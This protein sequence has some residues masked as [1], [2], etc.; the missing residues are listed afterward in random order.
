[1]TT[2]GR[3]VASRSLVPVLIVTATSLVI[4]L[5]LNPWLLLDSSTPSGGD[6][7]AHVYAPAYLRDVLL[8]HGRIGGWS[9]DWF[10]GFP[11]FYFYFPLPSIVIV[12][13]D[14][15][16]P[17]GVAFKLVT[18][19]GLIGMPPAVYY[20]TRSFRFN[21]SVST[22]A[23]S[24]SAVFVFMES[25]TIYGGNIASTLA[26]EF[27]YSWSFALGFV[28]LGLLARIL[29]GERDL[30]PKAVVVFAAAALSH[31]LTIIML[32]VCT[33]VFFLRKGAMGPVATVWLWA[34]L[35]TGFWSIPLLVRLPLST[36]MAWTPLSRWEEIFPIEMWLLIPFAIVGIVWAA[37]R[38][39]GVLP[40]VALTLLPLLYYPLPNLL[41]EF[42]PTMFEDGRWKF[43][44]GRM[45]PYW[46]FGVVYF[47][48]LSIGAAV[49]AWNRRLPEHSPRFVV[50][51]V[52]AVVGALT[53][54]QVLANDELPGWVGILV[55]GAFLGVI[56]ATLA[57]TGPVNTHSVVTASVAAVLAL[58]GLAG[59]TFVDGWARWNY[60]GYE[61]KETF[62]EYQAFMS[63]VEGL[64]AG[65]YQWEFNSELNQYGTTMSLML[66][67]F[68]V[69]Q[70]HQSMEG[71]F[72]ES[73][74]TV[75]FHFL[76]QAEM[77]LSPSRPVPGLDYHTF[78]FERGIPHLQLYGVDYYVSFTPEAEEKAIE[79]AR[80]TELERSGPFVI[81]EV[82]DSDLVEVARFEP[83][84][85]EPTA[86]EAEAFGDAA[87]EWYGS[88]A[89]LD[90]WL[91]ADGPDDWPRVPDVESVNAADAL[92]TT[93]TV[94]N[95]EIGDDWI[96]FDTDA[97]GVPHLVKVSYFPN[98]VATGA[99]GPYRAAPS[100]MV[101]VPTEKH[102]EM[103]FGR[104]WVEFVG[105]GATLLAIGGLVAARSVPA[106]RNR[107]RADRAEP[108]TLSD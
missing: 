53:V 27:S 25:F 17:Y 7:G 39:R 102:V 69:G 99:E 83:S 29:E 24:A 2:V 105:F 3:F 42:L 9:N 8:P 85:Y 74:L 11:L 61:G 68:W 13:L 94:S 33:A 77:S 19:L 104:S 73:S 14:V 16:L 86:S 50:R 32:V 90:R 66:I 103:R 22:I 107:L 4:L 44:N 95:I 75:P 38:S 100:L 91:V 35:L 20:M 92:E 26:G 72:F 89:T 62:G 64:P 81:F 5:V 34:G 43:W 63:G 12:I 79:D 106:I 101:V 41:P 84:V 57:W 97:I 28:Y 65:R 56:A 52:L 55:V 87:L 1:V 82:D 10:A 15:F 31:I 88:I 30:I 76:N 59:V 54:F 98:W 48:S 78:D 93:R 96:S 6:M 80:L 71:L 67:P 47:A 51:V 37:R 60:S 21:R 23:A 45:L 18:V 46:Y 36:D 70:G 58:G 49:S 40:V 108:A